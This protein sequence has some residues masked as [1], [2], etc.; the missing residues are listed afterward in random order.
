MAFDWGWGRRLAKLKGS[1]ANDQIVLRDGR[2]RLETNKIGGSLG[3]ITL[4]EPIYF[5]VWFKPTPSVRKPQKTVDLST[6]EET[7]IQ[8]KGR[9]D[10]TTVP[11]ALVALEAMAAVVIADH[12]LRS[13][14]VRRDKPSTREIIRNNFQKRHVIDQISK[15][16][17]AIEFALLCDYNS[18]HII[19]FHS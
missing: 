5:R 17:Y 19:L 12:A 16:D 1:E 13:G 2:P 11:K 7:T 10:V 8:F 14:L 4:G 15:S 6:L 18:P 3:G 9:Y